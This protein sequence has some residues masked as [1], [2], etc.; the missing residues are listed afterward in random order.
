MPQVYELRQHIKFV[1]EKLEL[2]KLAFQDKAGHAPGT[3]SSPTPAAGSK[4]GDG[5]VEPRGLSQ[6]HGP[7]A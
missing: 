3:V 6:S 4:P 7:A 1:I 2:R 5:G